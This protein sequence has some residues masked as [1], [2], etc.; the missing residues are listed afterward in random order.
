MTKAFTPT[1]TF[2]GTPVRMWHSLRQNP[3]SR[4][5]RVIWTCYDAANRKFER[6]ARDFALVAA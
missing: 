3:G 2:D 6:D 4:H 5:E 1:H